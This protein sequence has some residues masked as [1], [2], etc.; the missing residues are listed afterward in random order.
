MAD[1]EQIIYYE[2]LHRSTLFVS[3]KGGLINYRYFVMAYYLMFSVL[4]L[5]IFDSYSF[6]SDY[7]LWNVPIT[8]LYVVFSALSAREMSK[9]RGR[10]YGY[11]AL[12]STTFHISF[13]ANLVIN[14]FFWFKGSNRLE[15]LNQDDF[16]ISCSI[17]LLICLPMVIT[18][19]DLVC[20]NVAFNMEEIKSVVVFNLIYLI[21]NCIC[22]LKHGPIVGH[23]SWQD[24]KSAFVII[25]S[26]ALII[27][28]FWAFVKMTQHRVRAALK[29]DE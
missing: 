9:R 14:G 7:C 8:A 28:S 15:F 23:L 6:L 21:V 19:F 29:K 3:G 22:S 24:S 20:T 17:P 11:M 25:L 5:F 13:V 16:L 2:S 1:R 4:S 12:A 27:I 18:V 10:N 26:G